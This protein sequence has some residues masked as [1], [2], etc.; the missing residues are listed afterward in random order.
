MTT[1]DEWKYRYAPVGNLDL[2]NE[3]GKEGWEALPPPVLVDLRPFEN[4]PNSAYYVPSKQE[5]R[6]LMKRRKQDK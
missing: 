3:L 4:N 5:Y 6:I 2:L 1:N